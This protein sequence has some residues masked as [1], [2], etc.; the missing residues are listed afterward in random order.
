MPQWLTLTRRDATAPKEITFNADHILY[1]LP[2]GGD[3]DIPEYTV[4]LL[5]GREKFVVRE[6]VAEIVEVLRGQ[7]DVYL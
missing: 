3:D 1:F 6:T 5:V 4:V 2:G 7:E